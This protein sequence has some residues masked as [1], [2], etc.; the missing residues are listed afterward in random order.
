MP[1]TSPLKRR[2]AMTQITKSAKGC[3]IDSLRFDVV[4]VLI[5]VTNINTIVEIRP[6]LEQ[7]SRLQ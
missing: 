5:D 7:D 3:K 1:N 2:L 4:E 6:V